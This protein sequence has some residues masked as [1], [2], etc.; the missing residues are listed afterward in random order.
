[1][2]RKIFNEAVEIADAQQRADYLAAACGADAVL[3]Q[4]IEE[5][6][7]ADGDAGRFLGGAG[8]T[9]AK[10]R[11]RSSDHTGP[12]GNSASAGLRHFGDYELGEAL[13]RGGMGVVYKAMQVSLHRSVALKMIL[14]SELASPTAR[15]RFTLE[16]ETAARLDHP[17]IV[18]IYEVGEHEGQPFLSM[19]LITGENLRK[20]IASGDLC[21]TPKGHGTSKTSI[22]DRAL[23]IARL[24]ATMARAVQHAHENGV[25][26]RDL[27]PGNII[28]DRDGQPHLT[29]F[30]LAKMLESE[31]G[32]TPGVPLTVSGATLGTPSYMSPEQATGQR[33]ST[34]SDIYSL[35][36]IL[37]EMLAGQ[38]PFQGATLLETLRLAA[39][40]EAKRPSAINPRIDRDLDTVC[41]KCLEKNPVARYAT[42]EALAEDLER[43]L[44]HEPIQ[45]RPAHL[46]LRL[47]RWTRRNRAVTAMILGLGVGLAGALVLLQMLNRADRAKEIALRAQASALADTKRQ[48]GK[49][50]EQLYKRLDE[51]KHHNL[52]GYPEVIT[53]EERD[54]SAPELSAGMPERRYKVGIY[55][56]QAPTDM[57]HQF[58]P[59][60]A[61]LESK[62]ASNATDIVRLDLAIYG[63]YDQG[64]QALLNGEVDFMRM[65]PSSY[66]IA[67]RQNA[68]IELL[69]VQTY[70][71][72]LRGAIFTRE[73]AGLTN[74][75]GLRGRG[76]FAFGDRDSTSGNYLS[77]KALLEAGL[78]GR[79]LVG[80]CTNLKSHTEVRDAVIDGRFLAGAGNASAIDRKNDE[81]R[82]D[83]KA[84][85]H[86][87][88]R[89]QEPETPWVARQGLPPGVVPRLREALLTL[90][91]AK[92]LEAFQ[93]DV[94][95]FEKG[96]PHDYDELEKVMPE[97][98]IFEKR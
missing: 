75:A 88:L 2:L 47:Q 56:R 16:A 43:W 31:A 62:L 12:A 54:P 63:T 20:K 60:L 66:V 38:P 35:G 77:K 9:I 82:K 96:S 85:L 95:G 71:S 19:K 93:D 61:Y 5:L 41:V 6:I 87:L 36:A 98:E 21:L 91:D 49:I 80:C 26:H 27:K 30:G 44:R 86:I 40:Q 58:A 7:A 33:L 72:L 42:A 89:F 29:D 48:K 28:V 83:G 25:L 52:R 8:D 11:R 4:R 67:K 65:G 64:I 37:Y 97:A 73:D 53:S 3:R 34:A 84:G 59:I 92:I 50:Q 90:T 10:S 15:R 46:G 57:M 14:D 78:T 94:T 70:K 45:A 18:P 32:Q 22:Q 23:A 79:S 1:M 51:L 76:P 55:A 69:A 39:E 68:A 24:V 17:N 74:L 13:G 81:L